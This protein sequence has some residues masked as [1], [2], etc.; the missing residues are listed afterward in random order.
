MRPFWGIVCEKWQTCSRIGGKKFNREKKVLRK[1]IRNSEGQSR[2]SVRPINLG[3]DKM[4]WCSHVYNWLMICWIGYI[5]WRVQVLS[6]VN[7]WQTKLQ[8]FFIHFCQQWCARG[9]SLRKVSYE[10]LVFSVF[11]R[12]QEKTKPL[13]WQSV[14]SE[15]LQSL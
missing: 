1:W 9:M 6:L 5:H 15:A 3:K 11:S 2:A 12:N 14:S 13:T 10:A 7:F 8:K 4:I